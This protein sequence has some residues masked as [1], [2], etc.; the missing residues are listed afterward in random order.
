MYVGLLVL[1]LGIGIVSNNV[2]LVLLVAPM[3]LAI[4]YILVLP[5]ERYLLSQLGAQ[6]QAYMARVRRWI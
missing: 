6:Y 5:E 1:Q 2:W 3:F 4:K